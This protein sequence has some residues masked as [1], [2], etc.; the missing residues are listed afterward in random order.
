[1]APKRSLRPMH[2]RELAWQPSPRRTKR[3][4]NDVHHGIDRIRPVTAPQVPTDGPERRYTGAF[5]GDI[6][7]PHCHS[8][9]QNV[10][11][12]QSN[13]FWSWEHA[14]KSYIETLEKRC[15]GLESK[16]AQVLDIV[17]DVRSVPVTLVTDCAPPQKASPQDER[18][19]QMWVSTR[20]GIGLDREIDAWLKYFGPAFPGPTQC[21]DKHG[22]VAQRR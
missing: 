11:Y 18:V 1:M 3:V 16:L 15:S 19:A 22:K 14:A 2:P 10:P 8:F 17:N 21:G 5:A 6:G 9:H 12:A 20:M 7:E 4:S 13:G